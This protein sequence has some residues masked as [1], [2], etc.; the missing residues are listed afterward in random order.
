VAEMLETGCAALAVVPR[1]E[2]AP[3]GGC[4]IVLNLGSESTEPRS[5]G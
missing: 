1:L 3:G 4:L 2:R 5:R